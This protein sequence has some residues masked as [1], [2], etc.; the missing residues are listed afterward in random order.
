MDPPAIPI[1]RKSGLGCLV[2]VL[3]VFAFGV[4]LMCA[5]YAVFT[6]WAF[7]MGGQFHIYPGWTGW[8]RMHSN[9]SGDYVLLVLVK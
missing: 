4:V 8:G 1:R 2:Q 9:L 5:I 6:P 3:G 7:F